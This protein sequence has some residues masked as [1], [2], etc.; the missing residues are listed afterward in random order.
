MQY[1]RGWH[2]KSHRSESARL[3]CQHCV[4]GRRQTQ[5]ESA[6]DWRFRELTLRTRAREFASSG[7]SLTR[8][9]GRPR[10][11]VLG[12][13]CH[14]ALVNRRGVRLTAP[15]PRVIR[16]SPRV[17]SF[18]CGSMRLQAATMVET[19]NQCTIRPGVSTSLRLHTLIGVE[20]NRVR[21][22]IRPGGTTTPRMMFTQNG[23]RSGQLVGHGGLP[24]RLGTMKSTLQIVSHHRLILPTILG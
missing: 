3:A 24:K 21:D 5:G 7:E 16:R 4:H 18:T 23:P 13:R 9:R 11:L 2:S 8:A 1:R 15:T 17:P 14:G 22:R 12:T 20:R 19:P 6:I 10:R